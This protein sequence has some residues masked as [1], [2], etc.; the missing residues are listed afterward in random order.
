MHTTKMQ[1]QVFLEHVLCHIDKRHIRSHW[2]AILVGRPVLRRLG[3]NA[4]PVPYKRVVDVDIDGRAVALHL[5]VAG[6]VYL[7]PTA[8]VVVLLVEVS[9][10]FFWI[11]APMKQPLAIERYYFLALLLFRRQLQCG[12]IR[13]FVDTE[14][15][16]ILPVVSSLRLCC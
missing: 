13:Q 14:H 15:C 16:R 12:V 4:G 5:P 9:R 11:T 10:T 6:H 1:N 7:A 2:V 8:H 3:G